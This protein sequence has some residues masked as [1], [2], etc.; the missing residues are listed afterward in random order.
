MA[1]SNYSYPRTFSILVAS[2]TLFCFT[3]STVIVVSHSHRLHIRN[4]CP[5]TIWPGILAN[6]G[7]DHPENGGFRLEPRSI[8]SFQV[9]RAW[10]GQIW[11]RTGCDEASGKCQTGDCGNT[12]PCNGYGGSPP[13]NFVD[14]K[15]DGIGQLDYYFLSLVDGYNLQMEIRPV[16]DTVEQDVDC[17][18]SGCIQDLNTFC[19]SELVFTAADADKDRN[20]TELET[21]TEVIA[22]MSPCVAFNTDEYCCRGEYNDPRICRGEL[23]PI[24][25]TVVA[26]LA[27][28]TAFSYVF[29]Q[30]TRQNTCRSREVDSSEYEITFCPIMI[31]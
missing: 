29:D 1:R 9:E 11:G 31:F 18:P 23:W 4:S 2:F 15:F 6:F 22:C 30:T 19:P 5:Y 26:K 28:P 7:F 24:N 10:G 8:R 12:I 21:T 14:I 16:P 17:R 27:C 25:Y 20:S 13:F 3:I